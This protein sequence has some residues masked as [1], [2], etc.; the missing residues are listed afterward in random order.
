MTTTLPPKHPPQQPTTEP[1]GRTSPLANTGLAISAAG[2]AGW[3][4][5]LLIIFATHKEPYTADG[6]RNVLAGAHNF[7]AYLL[8]VA[9]GLAGL[10]ING[11]LSL[12]GTMVSASAIGQDS[13]KVSWVGVGLG[14]AGLLIGAALVIWRM[15]AWGVLDG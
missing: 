10:G 1:S 9:V 15:A 2:L 6:Q 13:R 3:L 7:L 12:V 11:T 8:Q 4:I 5:V 14:A